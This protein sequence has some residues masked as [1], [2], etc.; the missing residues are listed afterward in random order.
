MM[1]DQNVT[2]AYVILVLA[3]EGFNI[4]GT[5]LFG[6]DS[7]LV[8]AAHLECLQLVLGNTDAAFILGTGK[9]CEKIPKS[10][11]FTSQWKMPELLALQKI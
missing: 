6:T 1:L 3:E 2:K 11:K 8:Q 4:P 10:M 7:T 5:V 9:I